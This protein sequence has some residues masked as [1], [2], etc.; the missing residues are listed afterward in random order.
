ME[1]GCKNRISNF[2]GNDSL[3][4]ILTLIDQ[5]VAAAV[6]ALEEWVYSG[7]QILLG[8]NLSFFS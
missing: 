2:L 1:E 3:S 7:N 4:G 5:R 6:V 8:P